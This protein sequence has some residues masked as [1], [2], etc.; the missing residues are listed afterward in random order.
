MFKEG[1]SAVVS[2]PEPNKV[3]IKHVPGGKSLTSSSAYAKTNEYIFD[4][5]FGAESTQ[6]DVFKEVSELVR[7]AMD[8]YSVCIFSYGQTGS[9]KTFTMEGDLS[10]HENKGMIP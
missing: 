6:A 1:L 7:S 9:G 10:S 3:S 5:V 4:T 8:G 2:V